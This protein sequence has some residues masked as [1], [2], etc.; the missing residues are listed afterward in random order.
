MNWFTA[1]LVSAYIGVCEARVPSPYQACE[2]RWSSALAVLVPSPIQGAL[3][4]IGG[5][6]GGRLKREQVERPA[7]D[8][9]EGQS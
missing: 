2:A 4:A 6:L 9:R 1:L 3:P 7:T 5:L 8:R